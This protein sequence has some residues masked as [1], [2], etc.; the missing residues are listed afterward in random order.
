MCSFSDGMWR[1]IERLECGVLLEDWYVFCFTIG[2]CGQLI[3]A[4]VVRKQH[5]RAHASM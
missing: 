2:K 1:F 4:W 3:L 5:L